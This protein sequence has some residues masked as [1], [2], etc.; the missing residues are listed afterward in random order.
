MSRIADFF[1]GEVENIAIETGYSKEFLLDL[2]FDEDNVLD[3]NEFRAVA[4]EKDF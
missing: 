3:I 4:M 1:I 2:F